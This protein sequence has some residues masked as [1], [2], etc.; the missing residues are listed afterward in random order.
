MYV[1]YT[2]KSEEF[3][4]KIGV[5][6]SKLSETIA[7]LVI[8]SED[9][10]LL[11]E[12]KIDSKGNCTVPIKKMKNYLSEGSSGKMKL[13]VISEDTF[14]SP[15]EDEYSVKTNKKVTVEVTSSKETLKENRIKVEVIP[16]SSKK[17]TPIIESKEV[18]KPINHGKVISDRLRK[19]GITISNLVENKNDVI[20]IIKEYSEKNNL[21]LN[22]KTLLDDIINN[23]SF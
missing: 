9:V 19:K 21:K 8:E 3:K 4:C 2:D 11:F 1:I 12:G 5:E 18:N 10:N 6:G 23:L 17:E 14:F 20:S 13:E 7:R 16:Q 22:A 15:W